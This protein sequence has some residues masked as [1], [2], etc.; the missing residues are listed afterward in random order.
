MVDKNK[1]FSTKAMNQNNGID[2]LNFI[3]SSHTVNSALQVGK[4]LWDDGDQGV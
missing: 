1:T 4:A 2:S 3:Q